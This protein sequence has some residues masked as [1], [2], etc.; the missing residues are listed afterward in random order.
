MPFLLRITTH[1]DFLTR[2][3][4]RTNRLRYFG[5]DDWY[6]SQERAIRFPTRFEAEQQLRYEVDDGQYCYCSDPRDFEI[7]EVN[8]DVGRTICEAEAEVFGRPQPR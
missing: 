2:E 6:S 1:S 8:D 5:Y 4:F 3:A 7:V